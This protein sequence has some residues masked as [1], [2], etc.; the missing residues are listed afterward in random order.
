M[1]RR[2]A[3]L[4]AL[5][6]LGAG[7]AAAQSWDTPSFMS[8]R[9]ADDIG[10][11]SFRPDGGAWGFGAMWRQSGNV[12]LG[13]RAAIAGQEGARAVLVGAELSAPVRFPGALP[14][15]PLAIAWTAG[16]GASMNGV[17]AL[18][19][20][21]GLTAGVTL[22]VAGAIVVPYV[23]P[24]LAFGLLAETIAGEEV[25]ETEFTVPVDVGADVQL[26]ESIVLRIGFTLAD[27]NTVGAAVALRIPRRVVVR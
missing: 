11:Y 23:H 10:V 5:L 6:L 24:R 19:V 21:V 27:V 18:S 7:P 2:T 20:P 4:A 12:N 16:I 22:P 13:V 1:I 8:P 15:A 25:T 3:A 17:T 14:G 26:G 9:P